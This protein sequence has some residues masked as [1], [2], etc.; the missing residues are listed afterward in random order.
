MPE[1]RETQTMAIQPARKAL[2]TLSAFPA[3]NRAAIAQVPEPTAACRARPGRRSP[4]RAAPAANAASRF[5]PA[6]SEPAIADRPADTKRKLRE[7]RRWPPA[8]RRRT[9]R[10]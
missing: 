9:F 2:A 7:L 3:A 4:F 10:D 1:L 6:E 5:R 8:A